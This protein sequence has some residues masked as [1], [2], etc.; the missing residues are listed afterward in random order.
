MN[1]IASAVLA[2]A[3]GAALLLSGAAFAAGPKVVS[4]PGVEPQCF[5]PAT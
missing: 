5:L 1:K 4:G 2:A 3:V